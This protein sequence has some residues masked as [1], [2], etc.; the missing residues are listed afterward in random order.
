[1]P[2]VINRLGDGHT[3]KHTCKLRNT[4][5]HTHTHIHTHAY[6]HSRIEAIL[7]YQTP[8]KGINIT[9]FH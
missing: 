9:Y 1:M 8:L 6:R 7:I 5:T 2:I 4:H 3:H